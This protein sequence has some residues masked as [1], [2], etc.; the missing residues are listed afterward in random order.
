MRS[1]VLTDYLHT[2]IEVN[3][4]QSESNEAELEQKM[5]NLLNFVG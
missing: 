2:V 4:K 3:I 5:M 1:K